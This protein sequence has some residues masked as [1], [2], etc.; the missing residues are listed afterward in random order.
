MKAV[1]SKI[2]LLAVALVVAEYVHTGA[3]ALERLFSFHANPLVSIL[4]SGSFAVILIISGF[5]VWVYLSKLCLWILAAMERGSG[6]LQNFAR[7]CMLGLLRRA[8]TWL[9][10][11]AADG[12][13]DAA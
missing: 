7:R 1:I 12:A 13:H 6:A 8:V 11:G 9:E 10:K 2:P 3:G 5:C 4:A